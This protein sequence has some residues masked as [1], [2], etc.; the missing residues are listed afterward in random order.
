MIA[1]AGMATRLKLRSHMRTIA[2]QS[3]E[4]ATLGGSVSTRPSGSVGVP[5]EDEELDIMHDDF[6]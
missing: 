1:M 3:R 6:T 2:S 5:V 4:R